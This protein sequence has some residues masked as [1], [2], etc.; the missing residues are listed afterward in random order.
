[1]QQNILKHPNI[2]KIIL[3]FT[4]GKN[5]SRI[6][7]VSLRFIDEKTCLYTGRVVPN[8][9]KPRWRARAVVSIYTPEGIY[10]AEVIIRSVEYAFAQ[11][12]YE[13]DIPK[14]WKLGQLRTGIRKSVTLPLTLSF[15]DGT[16]IKAETV[17]LAVGG[18]AIVMNQEL[19]PLYKKF[20]CKYKIDFPAELNTSF[21]S[22]VLEGNAIFVRERTVND[23]DSL[24]NS[25]VF[26]FKF[27][28]LSPDKILALKNFLMKIDA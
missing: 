2:K 5:V 16:E 19:L 18:F 25:K 28:N 20:D 26:C 13:L 1:M 24:K 22:G 4:D 23:D 9:E 21:A 12:T 14:E 6:E 11:I 27:K 8:F 7:E 3:K 17:D 10:N 15:N